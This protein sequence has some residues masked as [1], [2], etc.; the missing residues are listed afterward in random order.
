MV[1]IVIRNIEADMQDAVI[2]ARYSSHAQKDTSIEDQ[3]ADIE[4]YARMNNL[5]ILKVY[6]DRHLTGRSDRRPQFQQMLRDAAHAKWR[7]V[8]VWKMDRFARNRY[9]SATYKYKLK[10]AGVQVLSA[11]ESIPEGPEGILLESMLEGYAEYYSA[12]LSQNVQRGMHYNALDCKVN[13]GAFPYG[14]CKGPDGKYAIH[15]GE[16]EVAREIFAKVAQ[17]VPFVEIANNLNGREIRTKRG[18][19]WNKNS[20]HRMLT[21]EAYIGV[22]HYGDVRIEGGM[23]AIV[24]PITF[25]GVQR[26]LE[27]KKGPQGRHQENGEYLLT[28]KMFCGYCGEPMIGIC[29]TGKSGSRYYYYVCRKRHDKKTCKK[30]NVGRDWIERE[31]TRVASEYILQDDVIEWVADSVM[32]YQAREA[33]NSQLADLNSQLDENKQVTANVMK[34]IEAG[35]I[36]STTRQRLLELEADAA[37]IA[38]AIRLEEASLTHIERDQV[39]YWMEKFRDGDIDSQEFR[40]KIIHTFV[41]AVY[42]T[43]DGLRLVFNYSGKNNEVNMALVMGAED[44]AGP[45]CSYNISHG[46]P[47]QNSAPPGCCS[48]LVRETAGTR[49]VRKPRYAGGISHSPVRTLGNPSISAAGRNANESPT[50]HQMRRSKKMPPPKT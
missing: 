1:V 17:G 4:V 43:D 23:P 45:G 40:R 29:G 22:Y 30:E 44:L 42:L 37:R 10:K 5:R 34:A 25:L 48:V 3:V 13:S 33:A 16:A 47:K 36:T 20:F 32:E 8:I 38:N 9:D 6:A 41:A 35:I 50:G 26:I 19:L 27:K 2:Y 14:Y 24:D 15:E 18:G 46:S 11:K 21:N 31:V 39:I 28:G 49:I 12:S 7:Y